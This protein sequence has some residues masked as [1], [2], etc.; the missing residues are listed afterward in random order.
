MPMPQ[1]FNHLDV[2]QE[3][4]G[5]LMDSWHVR[6][7]RS[8]LYPLLYPLLNTPWRDS[9]AKASMTACGV[10]LNHL[11][12]HQCR[13]AWNTVAASPVSQSC[14]GETKASGELFL[15]HA[16]L[17][18]RGLHVDGARKMYIHAVLVTLGMS[19]GLF[20]GPLIFGTRCSRCLLPPDF[21][22]TSDWSA[23]SFRPA[24]A[25]W[26]LSPLANSIRSVRSVAGVASWGIRAMRMLLLR[27]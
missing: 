25:K 23:K 13:V 21:D 3:M 15:R 22:H 12:Q 11:E 9:H 7:C 26:A 5:S 19:D 24:L 20:P 17:D 27:H 10:T 2:E 6:L 4:C 16:H 1:H 8:L 18:P 14:H